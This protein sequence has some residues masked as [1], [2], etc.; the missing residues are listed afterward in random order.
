M[1]AID[2]V[3]LVGFSLSLLLDWLVLMTSIDLEEVHIIGHSLGAHVAGVAGYNTEL[4]NVGRI[5]GM[6]LRLK[7]VI[8]SFCV[9]LIAFK[10]DEQ[11]TI[12]LS[13]VFLSV[14]F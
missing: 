10:H 12:D 7:P 8:T 14:F 11:V 9:I 1:Q 5:T 13:A 3:W 6:V 4:G 2:S